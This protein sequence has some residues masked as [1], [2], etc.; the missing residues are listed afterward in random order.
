MSFFDRLRPKWKHADPAIRLEAVRRLEDQRALE[1]IVEH[2]PAA[3]VR[4]AAI[5]ALTSQTVIARVALSDDSA[6]AREVAVARIE[7]PALLL[8]I[9]SSDQSATVRAL[10][11]TKCADTNSAGSFLRET[12]TKLQVGESNPAHVADFCGTLDEVCQALS[13][14]PRFHLNG[15]LNLDEEEAGAVQLRDTTRVAW[16]TGVRHSNRT[17]ARFVAQTRQQ[18]GDTSAVAGLTR[19]FHIK[20]WRTAE[21]RFDVRAEEKQFFSTHD[22]VAWSRASGDG[23][24]PQPVAG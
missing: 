16:T 7:D 14:D 21:N 9:A 13:V 1:S 15:N 4:I 12:L 20:V 22:A 2:D 24:D 6:T 8:R 3:E 19:F 10:A 23:L 5:R 17:A 18:A 11:R